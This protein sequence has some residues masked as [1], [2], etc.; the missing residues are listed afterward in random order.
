MRYAKS[1]TVSPGATA[2][3]DPLYREQW[4]WKKME[5]MVIS[6]TI[7]GTAQCSREPLARGE[8]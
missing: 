7:M 6:A 1:V 5:E 2:D 3:S 8:Q 4:A